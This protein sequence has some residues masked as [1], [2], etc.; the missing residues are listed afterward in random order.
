MGNNLDRLDK[1]ND[2]V[3]EVTELLM[4]VLNA[5]V[6]ASLL[7]HD[8][9]RETGVDVAASAIV[10]T[11]CSFME[12]ACDL[13]RDEHLHLFNDVAV[14]MSKHLKVTTVIREIG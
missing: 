13:D 4:P 6:M 1:I 7:R 5:G 12:A 3:I 14:A 2:S 10:C 8:L 11:L 9:P